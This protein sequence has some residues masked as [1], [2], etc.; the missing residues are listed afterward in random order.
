M[1]KAAQICSS[2]RDATHFYLGRLRERLWLKPALVCLLSI[3]TAFAASFADELALS[4]SLPAISLESI[5]TLLT[6]MSSSMLVIAVFAV[7]AM[8][9]AYNAA[10]NAA[11]P[12]SFHLV[13]ADD[14]SQN[15]LS[16][17]IG[18][19]IFSIVALV[20]ILN[21]L[22][23]E[24]GRFVLFVVTILVFAIVILGFVRWV[25]RIAR[26]GRLGHT[27]SKVEAQ[28]D[29]A[30][31]SRARHPTLKAKK[32][33]TAVEG[34]A[35]YTRS[36][37][38]VQRVDIAKLQGLSEQMDGE[39]LVCALPG[40]F[41]TPEKPLAYFTAAG[42]DTDDENKKAAIAG[43]FVIASERTFEEDPRF[44]LI[45]LSEIA[46]RALSPAVNDSGTAIA[47]VGSLVRLFVSWLQETEQNQDPEVEYERV[48]V[49]ELSLDDLFDDAF[50][51]IA[52]DG[53]GTL[54]VSIRLQKALYSLAMLGDEAMKTTA[55]EHAKRAFRQ[56]EQSMMQQQELEV[57]QA[58]ADECL[59]KV[60]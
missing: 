17:F 22:Y 29:I 19:F 47:I 46:S 16:T 52:R 25:D 7:G 23:E 50:N 1:S 34:T 40:A 48:S 15:A 12:R 45:V 43:A 44:G 37:G 41:V 18:A 26:L 3:G 14:V 8:L 51:A 13:L 20:A 33:S 56:S 10:S 53:A 55:I 32:A 2:I 35:I 38:Y 28:A 6:I 30:L 36:V 54:E 21:G 42:S 59:R 24:T 57:L 5:E 11:T 39:V 49:P 27:I 58:V 9:S 31:N 4:F 60:A